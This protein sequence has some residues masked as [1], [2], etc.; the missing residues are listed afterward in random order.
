MLMFDFDQV[1]E[2]VADYSLAIWSVGLFKSMT[3]IMIFA[4]VI[5][6]LYMFRCEKN[7]NYGFDNKTFFFWWISSK[8]YLLIFSIHGILI[9]KML[10]IV[11]ETGNGILWGP[12]FLFI[13]FAIALFQL[14]IGLNVICWCLGTPLWPWNPFVNKAG[15]DKIIDKNKRGNRKTWVE[16]QRKKREQGERFSD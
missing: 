8:S 15:L 14:R 9:G 7:Q 6:V 2:F 13:F 16:K 12:V 3:I 1:V 11:T 10:G 5:I 4:Y